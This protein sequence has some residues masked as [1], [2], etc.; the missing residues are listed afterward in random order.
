MSNSRCD[1]REELCSC[2]NKVIF[3]FIALSSVPFVCCKRDIRLM[4]GNGVNEGRIEILHDGQYGTICNNRFDEAAARVACRMLGFD[5]NGGVKLYNSTK[6]GE[7]KEKIW[8]DQV[9]C[10]GSEQRIED[11][12]HGP[13]GVHH[14][15]HDQDVGLACLGLISGVRLVG[16][17]EVNEGRI[18]IRYHGQYGTICNNKFDEAAAKVICRMVGFDPN[19]GV[20]LYN[21]TKFGEGKEE[22]WLDQVSCDGSEQRIE[23]CEHGPWGVHHCEHDQDVGLA[24]LGL[25]SGV[26]LVGGN[27]ENEGRIEIRYHGQYGTICDNTFDEA[28]AKVICRMLGFDADGGVEIHNST[29]FGQGRFEPIWLD[30]VVC[31]G[32]EQTL[33]DC[34]LGRWGVNPCE[35]DEDVGVVCLG[36]PYRNVCNTTF[37]F[38]DCWDNSEIPNDQKVHDS[39]EECRKDELPIDDVAGFKDSNGIP[40]DQAVR[41]YREERHNVELP[42]DD[43]AGCRDNNGI[44]ND[45]AVHDSRDKRCND[46]RPIHNA[47][48]CVIKKVIFWFIALSSVPLVCCKRD[49]RL[50]HGNG[51]HEG[52]IEILHDNQYGTI[53]NNKFDEAAARVA[54]RMLGFDPNGGVKLYNSTK[55]GE[56]K[57]EIWLDQVSCDGSERRIEDCEHGPWGEHHCEH[58]QDVGL[59][60]LGLISGVRLVGGNEVNEGRIE[61]RYHG[62]YGTICNNK[63]DEAAAKVIC[64]MVGF[65]PNRG[66]KLYNSTKFGEG[67]EEIWLDQVSCNGS[68]QRLQECEHGP[69]A[70]HHCEHDQDV[71][72]A[73]LGLISGVRL[74]GGNKENEGRIEIRYH[75]QYGTICDEKFDEAAA[76][77][78]CRMLG[79]DADGGVEIHNSTTFG[80][81][82]FE[83]IWIDKVVCDGSEQTLEDCE[84]GRWGVN[85]CEHDKDVGVVCLGEPYRVRLVGG[86]KENEGRIE[87]RYHGQYGT[88]CDNTFD[89]AAAKVICRMLGFDADGGVEIHN[90]TTFGQ[91][92][93]E[94]IW[95]D[96][97][98]CD[99]SE[100]TLEDCELGR[101]GVNH[102]EHDKDVGVVCLGEPYQNAN[103]SVCGDSCIALSSI[104]TTVVLLV[105]IGGLLYYRHSSA[106]REKVMNFQT[107]EY[108]TVKQPAPERV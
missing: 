77:V 49:I 25:I 44:P 33:E 99:G 50:M 26:R 18:E 6:F 37:T 41:D 63:F 65:D 107:E 97:V 76:R 100:Q 32:S 52:R 40:N 51:V 21:S 53:C 88:I 3:L 1:Y 13:W 91:G 78:I 98:V 9:F 20:K 74:V 34:E 82:R 93:F 38:T 79:F 81:G 64:R 68:E 43:V 27:K 89:E 57:E 24:C 85:H 69:W 58:D 60:C 11:C 104:G 108:H 73:C 96:K 7:G 90:S 10:D 95:I 30:K 42:T 101:W 28:A 16:G 102:C 80:Q 62:Q 45:Q 83:P 31:D 59:A 2:V 5:L 103:D 86:N 36:E 87:I 29:T 54:C 66:V 72:L 55:F 17:N 48:G 84:L 12:E 71:G 105:L 75:G 23:D 70:V 4:H 22:I 39:R 46:E 61:I 8:L 15:E 106:R 56:G 19:R 94:L 35:H 14:C 67:K 92:R 47:A